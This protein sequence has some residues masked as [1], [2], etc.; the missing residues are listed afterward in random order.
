M[1]IEMVNVNCQVDE[2]N[3]HQGDGPLAMPVWET[4]N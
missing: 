3:I 4:L 2:T 1:Y